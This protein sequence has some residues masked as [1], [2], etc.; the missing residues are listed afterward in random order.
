MVPSFHQCLRGFTGALFG[1]VN[2]YEL[3][4]A[5][6]TPGSP[7][8]MESVDQVVVESP[9]S[10]D[11]PVVLLDISPVADQLA[12]RNPQESQVSH[13][14]SVQLL[15]NRV[16]ENV[17]FDTLGCISRF[18]GVPGDRRISAPCLPCF[19]TG[20]RQLGRITAPSGV[21]L[22]RCLLWTMQQTC[23]LLSRMR[24]FS[25]QTPPCCSN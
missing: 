13:L 4:L 16:R 7:V 2:Y 23:T 1:Y 15:P 6:Q 17:D 9:T 21:Q 19:V 11:A 8:S 3:V 24:W 20:T 18:Y 14:P 25:T 22:C 5:T 10:Y 12:T